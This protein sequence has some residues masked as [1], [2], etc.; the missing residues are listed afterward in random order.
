MWLPK[1]FRKTITTSLDVV[2]KDKN[3]QPHRVMWLPKVSWLEPKEMH[4]SNQDNMEQ[5]V[6]NALNVTSAP[7]RLQCFAWY[8][9]IQRPHRDMNNKQPHRVMWLPKVSRLE[10][11]TAQIKTSNHMVWCGYQK[12]SNDVVVTS[13]SSN[14][15]RW[16][17]YQR[18]LDLIQVQ[19]KLRQATTSRDMITNV[20]QATISNDVITKTKVKQA[21]ISNDVVTKSETTMWLWK[22]NQAIT[23]DASAPPCPASS[24]KTA[25]GA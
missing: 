10:Q 12:C 8:I 18:C 22:V 14:H 23:S 13:E 6:S 9:L 24:S 2:T 1:V 3:K 11:G 5:C 25:Q 4:S 17:D 15:I 7:E 19:L 20:K 16:C 21:T